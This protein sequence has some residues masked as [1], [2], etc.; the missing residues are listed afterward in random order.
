MISHGPYALGL[1]LPDIPGL[2]NGLRPE[3]KVTHTLDP[4][5]KAMGLRPMLARAR[6]PS[7]SLTVACMR[8][9][10]AASSL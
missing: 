10:D 7:W 2:R 6:L 9:C 8:L 3:G 4:N 5:S 1:N